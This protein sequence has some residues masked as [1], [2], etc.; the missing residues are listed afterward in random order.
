MSLRF[1]MLGIAGYS[2]RQQLELSLDYLERIP[3]MQGYIIWH[4]MVVSGK[5]PLIQCLLTY[6]IQCWS[7]TVQK[8]CSIMSSKR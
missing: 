8:S 3:P 7:H 5:R 1:K 4:S 6:L 2:Y